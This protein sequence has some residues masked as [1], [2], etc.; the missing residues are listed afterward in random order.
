M[1]NFEAS[2]PGI[3]RAEILL[4]FDLGNL[5]SG[6]VNNKKSQISRGSAPF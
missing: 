1:F 2:L 4:Y 5:E 6:L 3:D